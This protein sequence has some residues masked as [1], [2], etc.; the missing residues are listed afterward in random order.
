MPDDFYYIK[1]TFELAKK[2]E[3]FTSPNP[4][5]GAVITKKNKIISTGYH[6]KAGF[7]HAEIEAIRK[8]KENAKG[9]TLYINLEPCCHWGRTPPCVDEII[10]AR[11]K[12]VVVATYDPNP[13]VRG[14]SLRKLKKAG[15]EVSIGV[16]SQEAE[17]LNEVFFRN[18]KY[19][20]PFVAAKVAQSL[21]GKIAT[22]SG[23]SKWITASKARL[24]SKSLRDKYDAVLV[25]INTVIKDNPRL[26][27]IKK[28]PFKI[29]VDPHLK[30][31]FNA[32]LLRMAKNNLIIFASCK[33]KNK[34]VELLRKKCTIYFLEEKNNYMSFRKVIRILYKRGITSIFVEGGSVTLG[35]FFDEKCIDKIYFFFAPK[36]IG[37]KCAPTSI[38]GEGISQIE[39]ACEVRDIRIRRLGSD[40]LAEGYPVFKTQN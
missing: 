24:F 25:G 3:G 28:E 10:A 18:M 33:V 31:P 21:D 11:I 23:D 39:K 12:R 2:G 1:K 35:R 32:T 22:K 5:V 38:A 26:A 36:I 19:D 27:G 29:V 9:S 6:K 40:F 34:K 8:A 15:I 7:P 37:G 14:K 20:L 17:R 30:I 13:R 4:L 16:L